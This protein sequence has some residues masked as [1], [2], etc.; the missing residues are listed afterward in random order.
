VKEPIKA[1]GHRLRFGLFELDLE[2]GDLWRGTDLVRLEPQ[3]LKVLL[4]LAGRPG[5]LVQRKEI[6][7]QIWPNDTFVD[8]EQ[9]LN[10]CIRRIRAVLGDSAESPRFIETIPRRG[11]RF[12]A[13]V[14]PPRA[15]RALVAVLPFENLSGDAEKEYF[16]DGL[17]EEMISQLGRLNP[18]QLGVIA[19]TS[20]MRYK[21]TDKSID[22]I[23]RELGV[24]Y[25]LEGSVRQTVDRVRVT[26]QLVQV[27]DQTPVW[28]DSFERGV[29]DLLALQS[30]VAHAIARQIG[31][32]LTA[33]EK[34]R[35]AEPRRVESEAYEAY[36]K[37]RYFWKRRS[38]D[39]LEKSVH[40]FQQ[41]IAIDSAF[42]PAY[43]G[44][45]DVRLTQLD[46]D[47]LA[48]REA[49]ARAQEAL[50]SALR[51]DET[52]A[53]PHASLGHLR[54][55]QLDWT[56]AERAFA[57]AIELNAGYDTAH[58]YLSNLL[59]ALGRF[60][61]ALAEAARAV[62][63]DPMTANT[64]QNRMFIL[65][66]ARRYDQ[67]EAEGT[68][69]LEMDPAHASVHYYLG[70]VYER[71]GAYDEALRAFARVSPGAPTPGRRVLAA[72]GYTHARAGERTAALETLKSLEALAKNQY[73]SSYEMALVHVALG[74]WD[75][76]FELLSNAFEERSSFLPFLS[77]DPRLDEV[78]TDERYHALVARLRLPNS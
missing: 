66:L 34:V 46:Y 6:Q 28:T 21:R 73:G 25:V 78:R 38:R 5:Q 1:V 33:G 41:A 44:L 58:Y 27:S 61:E 49:F 55:H 39:A 69:T 54:L 13:R 3:P 77:V 65:Y 23:G 15:A 10:Y 48:P 35:L 24:S 74:D 68:E 29:G 7:G 47:Y 30:D 22:V 72:T 43:A 67:A 26:A 36:L 17:T 4:L 76:A 64:R 62:V 63:C 51:L 16:S 70:L 52:L 57:R 40:Y 20:A 9:G 8:F 19:R 2:S 18:T 42:A 56:A 12:V 32:Q 53:E 11:Y 14:E 59:A 45:A 75:R 37:G 60:E 71:Q 31:V 50:T